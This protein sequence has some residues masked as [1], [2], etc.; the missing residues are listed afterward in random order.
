MILY[1]TPGI[2]RTQSPCHLYGQHGSVGDHLYELNSDLGIWASYGWSLCFLVEPDCERICKNETL[3][4]QHCHCV[5]PLLEF[6]PP[7]Q[8]T[9]LPQV[10]SIPLSSSPCTGSLPWEMLKAV[11]S[12]SSSWEEL[13]PTGVTEDWKVW[14][15]SLAQDLFVP[16]FLL[17][18]LSSAVAH[19]H[20]RMAEPLFGRNL[21]LGFNM[22]PF[23]QYLSSLGA[24]GHINRNLLVVVVV[25]DQAIINSLTSYRC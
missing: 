25:L 18:A 24:Q 16:D 12:D 22:R 21:F 14:G 8:D 2:A 20:P 15:S 4:D 7:L 6:I 19:L 23:F 5:L 17:L 10:S 3:G 11:G 1:A 13:F 9:A